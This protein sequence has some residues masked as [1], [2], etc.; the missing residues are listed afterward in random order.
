MKAKIIDKPVINYSFQPKVVGIYT[1][2]LS[3][4]YKLRLQIPLE[5]QK[6]NYLVP[7]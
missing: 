4:E 6:C 2:S 7:N 3:F 5:L 1:R